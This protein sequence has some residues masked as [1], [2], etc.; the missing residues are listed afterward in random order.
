MSRRAIG[1]LV[2]LILLVG[3]SSGAAWP[4]CEVDEFSA[5]VEG[6]ALIVRHEAATYNCCMDST[7]YTVTQSPGL[8][9]I[10]EFEAV[11]IPCLCLCC[12]DLSVEV[13]G[14]EPGDYM[15]VFVWYDYDTG[16]P[17]QWTTQVTVS[18]PGG[19]PFVAATTNSGCLDPTGVAPPEI[20]SGSSWGRVKT[21]YE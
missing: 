7:T 14:L 17:E 19:P 18:G 4:G 16:Q 6:D 21:L 9:R 20:E 5:M 3:A 13:G 2:A 8:I 1:P 15:L 10:E 12:Y 11:T